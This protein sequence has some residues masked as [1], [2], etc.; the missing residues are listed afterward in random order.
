MEGIEE[1]VR[2]CAQQRADH[3]PLELLTMGGGLAHETV[4]AVELR[5]QEPHQGEPAPTRRSGQVEAEG[6]PDPRRDR[7]AEHGLQLVLQ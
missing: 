3:H 4:F 2:L 7:T 1:V 6:E 5:Q